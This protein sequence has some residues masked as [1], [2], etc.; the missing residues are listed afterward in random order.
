MSTTIFATCLTHQGYN[1][2][3]KDPTKPCAGCWQARSKYIEGVLADARVTWLTAALDV[4]VPPLVTPAEAIGNQRLC[5]NAG[6]VAMEDAIK[7]L[8]DSA[9]EMIT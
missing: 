5:Y 7:K 8:I 9:E 4:R 6:V 1:P 3:L 2:T